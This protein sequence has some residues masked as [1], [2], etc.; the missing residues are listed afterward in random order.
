MDIWFVCLPLFIS[1]YP[2]YDSCD[3]I[4]L[5]FCYRTSC[6]FLDHSDTIPVLWQCPDTASKRALARAPL[7]H[8][9]ALMVIE[10]L[11]VPGNSSH[12][13]LARPETLGCPVGTR[14]DIL[15][16]VRLCKLKR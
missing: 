7:M 12:R 8:T 3:N 5:L 15:S 10:I 9:L 16:R 14:Q 6:P 1:S 11:G 2:F 13:A 4:V